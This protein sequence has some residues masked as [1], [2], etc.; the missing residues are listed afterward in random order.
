MSTVKYNE[1]SHLQDLKKLFNNKNVM[2]FDLETTGFSTE[3]EVFGA[4]GYKCYENNGNY[5][6]ARILQVGWKY[7]ENWGEEFDTDNIAAC[8]RKSRDIKTISNTNIHGITMNDIN[9]KGKNMKNILDNY[10]FGYSIENADYIIAHNAKFDIPIL[11]NE[12]HR[13]GYHRKI[14]K[15]INLIENNGIICTLKYGKA[16]CNGSYKL[17]SFYQHY[18]H[19]IPKNTHKADGDVK[20]LL[21]ILNKV[22]IDPIVCNKSNV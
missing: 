6:T 8:F 17:E 14:H 18:Y 3:K 22:I 13:I 9:K 5:Q 15:I 21:D 10:G 1:N 4:H 2:V 20:I 11:L 7:I 19:T 16:I 12:L